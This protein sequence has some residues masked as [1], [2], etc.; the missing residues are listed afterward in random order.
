VAAAGYVTY[1]TPRTQDGAA[2][3]YDAA[4]LRLQAGERAA[5]AAVAGAEDR[6]AADEVR[7]V[8]QG[9]G[10]AQTDL[11]GFTLSSMSLP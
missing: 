6:L 9:D 2:R 7:A 10:P 11:E 3:P 1:L 8:V 5:R 4:L